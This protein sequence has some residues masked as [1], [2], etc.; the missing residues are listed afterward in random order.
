[1]PGKSNRTII[2]SSVIPFRLV[3]FMWLVFALDFLYG[4]DIKFLGIYPRTTQGLAGILFAPIIHGNF[5]HLLSNTMPLIFLGGTLFY[6]Y[7]S[8]A[9]RIFA[10]CYFGT[11]ILVWIFARPSYHIGA[12][13]IVY[14]IAAFLIAFGFF[15]RDFISLLIAGIVLFIYGSIFYGVLPAGNNV[16]WESHLFGALIGVVF[17]SLYRKARLNK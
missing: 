13:G 3:F 8:I 10:A 11:N 16:S 6:Y 17:A 2:G 9:K 14:A 15:R 4:F 12:S 7:N 1:M 5:Q